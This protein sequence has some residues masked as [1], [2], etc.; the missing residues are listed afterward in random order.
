MTKQ[1]LRTKKALFAQFRCPLQF[2]W[3]TAWS[4]IT[5]LARS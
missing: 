2:S 3:T 1:S 4:T 5:L